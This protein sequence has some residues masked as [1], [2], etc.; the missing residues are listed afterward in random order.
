MP[1]YNWMDHRNR[2]WVQRFP[3][4]ARGSGTWTAQQ[5]GDQWEAPDVR[6]LSS[7]RRAAAAAERRRLFVSHRQADSQFALRIAWLAD[8]EGF[9][10]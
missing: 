1:N 2:D 4:W 8:Q 3:L 6:E 5:R 7:Q 10:F 9:E